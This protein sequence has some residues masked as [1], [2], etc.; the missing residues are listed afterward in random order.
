MG[1]AGAPPTPDKLPILFQLDQGCKVAA[2]RIRRKS[3]GLGPGYSSRVCNMVSGAEGS[4]HPELGLM[5]LPRLKGKSPGEP[6]S[7]PPRD[8]TGTV[9]APQTPPHPI[10][11]KST[12]GEMGMF[13]TWKLRCTVTHGGHPARW[14]WGRHH[15]S[16]MKVTASQVRP[17]RRKEEAGTLTGL[18]SNYSPGRGRKAVPWGLTFPRDSLIKQN[19]N[20]LHSHRGALFLSFSF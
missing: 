15:C 5:C 7:S 12:G 18:G 10:S 20:A 2:L 4:S 19:T 9:T 3:K 14:L 1:V 6:T 11:L 16:L 17:K 8:M 13:L